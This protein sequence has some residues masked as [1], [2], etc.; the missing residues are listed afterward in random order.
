M[1]YQD[2]SAADFYLESWKNFKFDRQEILK[3]LESLCI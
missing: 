1:D 2:L 3:T